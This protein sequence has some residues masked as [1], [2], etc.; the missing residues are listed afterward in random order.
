[1]FSFEGS[2]N[3]AALESTVSDSGQVQLLDKPDSWS[4]SLD[5]DGLFPVHVRQVHLGSCMLL[6]C[7]PCTQWSKTLHR[8]L[9]IFVWRL[10][11]DRLPTRFNLSLKGP[12]IPS[13]VFP[14]C[15]NVVEP[16]NHVF[17]FGVLGDKVQV[18]VIFMALLWCLY[19]NNVTFDLSLVEEK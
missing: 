2:R 9:N 1:M 13:I 10:S 19:R 14:I 3:E 11:F 12:D 6:L 4:W 17:T 7:S 15:K 5:D 16:I 8:K 18:Y